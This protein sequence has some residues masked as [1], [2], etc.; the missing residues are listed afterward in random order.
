MKTFFRK[1]SLF[2]ILIVSSTVAIAQSEADSLLTFIQ[3]HAD[4]SSLRL[5]R[6]DSLLVSLNT[7][8]VMPLASTVKIMVALEFAKQA[9]HDIFDPNK[10]V[11]LSDLEKYY[12]PNTDGNAHPHWIDYEKKNG[13]INA[14]SVSL[15]E[16]A[17]GMMMFSSNANTEYLMD[18]LGLQN[19]NQN[20]KL[21]SIKSYTPA[22]YLVSSLFLYQN[23][24]EKAEDKVLKQIRSLS[25]LDYAE[26]TEAIH[27]QL[28]LN[29]EYKSK[30]RAADLTLP[31][32]RLWSD[33]LPASTTK[34]YT[35]IAY[36]INHRLIFKADTY[37]ILSQILETIMQNAANQQWL[38][39]AG[40][41]GG[42]TAFV[43]TKTLYATLKNGDQI[44]LAYFLDGLTPQENQKLQGWMNPFE[45]R[46]LRDKTFVDRVKNALPQNKYYP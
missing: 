24:K 3:K 10:L 17:K 39:H 7:N 33:R 43:L 25:T 45:L 26:A 44:E 30:F 8:K 32:Q 37:Q 6:N 31:M 34:A 15:M 27:A 20:Y 11:A 42:S 40:M 13:N 21:L 5:Q 23:P 28:K 2:I 9:S 41:K 19:I 29:P 16:V 35:Q 12:I 46:I 4:N 36:I 18:L 1:T 38:T 22:Y 14:D